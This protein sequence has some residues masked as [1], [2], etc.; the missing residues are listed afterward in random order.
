LFDKVRAALPQL[1]LPEGY[2]QV[3]SELVR[4]EN[5][6]GDGK[7]NEGSNEAGSDEDPMTKAEDGVEIE[8]DSVV[9]ASKLVAVHGSDEDAEV[10]STEEEPTVMTG[11]IEDSASEG[12][13]M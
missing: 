5:G 7:E 2:Q 12:N 4:L 8:H 13:T 9:I 10:L 6:N 11:I 1:Q 3:L